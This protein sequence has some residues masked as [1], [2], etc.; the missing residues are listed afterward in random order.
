MIEGADTMRLQ[1]N[2]A[3]NSY[4]LSPQGA[5][6]DVPALHTAIGGGAADPA[7]GL[8][9]LGHTV[10]TYFNVGDDP[11]GAFI[12]KQMHNESI[13]IDYVQTI[14]DGDTASS[15][16][17]PSYEKNHV[18]FV[19]AGVNKQLSANHFPLD[20]LSELDYLFIGPLSGAGKELLAL[21]A[22]EAKKRGITV[23]ANP[24]MAQLAQP[25]SSFI[26]QLA[27]IDCL[28][29]NA[30]EAATLLHSLTGISADVS[31]QSN[32]YA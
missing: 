9:R 10:T 27:S 17:I 2:N 7:V 19:Y 20:S 8:S 16:I 4:L 29:L 1:S 5:K 23:V 28:I 3:I 15:F 12:K 6:I 31:Y 11:A 21:L 14:P 22:P 32:G 18:A 24:G 13:S 30:R 25:Q 26:N